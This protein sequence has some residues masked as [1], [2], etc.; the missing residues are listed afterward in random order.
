MSDLSA[1]DAALLFAHAKF[2]IDRLEDAD[3]PSKRL[4][5]PLPRGALTCG[6]ALTFF[7][8]VLLLLQQKFPQLADP[9]T[10]SELLQ[11]AHTDSASGRPN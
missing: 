5:T 3:I 11:L 4:A 9:E 2:I 6:E 10:L 7:P 1:H 8:L